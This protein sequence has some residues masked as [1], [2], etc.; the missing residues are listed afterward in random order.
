MNVLHFDGRRSG[1][2]LLITGGV[3][4]DEFEPIAAIR[5]LAEHLTSLAETDLCGRVTLVPIVNEPAFFKG[6]RC[7]EDGLDLA[8]VCPGKSDGSVTERLAARLS[9]LIG[10]ADLYIDL[11][12][13]GT[14]YRIQ[15][16]AGYMLH[17]DPVVLERQRQMARAFGL[18]IVWGTSAEL[19]GRSLSVARDAGVPAIY[20]EY[21]GSACCD[22]AGVHAYVDGCLRVMAEVGLLPPRP[23]SGRVSV[24]VEDASPESGHLQVSHPAPT[25]GF[26]TATVRGGESVEAGQLLGT[27][28]DRSL[29][30]FP[31]TADHAGLLI[32]ERTF[33]R[34]RQGDSCGVVMPLHG[35]QVS[36]LPVRQPEESGE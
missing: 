17:P 6:C 9:D 28:H 16:L 15:P 1:P 26:F 13:G 23:R 33:P 14:E 10:D 8:R 5:T 34:V 27:V 19:Q 29:R 11:H 30:K 24:A 21:G 32:M 31:V 36:S 35:P 20:C 12:S 7:A 2:R 3:H 25:D 18:P 4:G 22:P